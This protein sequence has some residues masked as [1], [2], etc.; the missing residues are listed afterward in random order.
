[1]MLR[2]SP[3]LMM[4]VE[5]RNVL[6]SAMLLAGSNEA[7]RL[8]TGAVVQATKGKGSGGGGGRGGGGG[9]GKKGDGGG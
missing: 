6:S 2:R 8:S 7:T 1:M 5:T 4:T 3:R 9:G